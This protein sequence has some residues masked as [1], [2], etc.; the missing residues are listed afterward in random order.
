L[1]GYF[2]RQ[3]TFRLR[4][5]NFFGTD[6]PIIAG[7][8]FGNIGTGTSFIMSCPT[9]AFIISFFGRLGAIL[10]AVGVVCSDGSTLGPFGDN[11]GVPS[12]TATCHDGFSSVEV[13]YDISNYNTIGGIVVDCSGS[14]SR[15]DGYNSGVVNK[16]TCPAGQVLQTVQGTEGQYVY[17]LQFSCTKAA[18]KL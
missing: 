17:S 13:D 8:K 10:D 1:G 11:G 14:L 5:T 6:T 3:V 15:L 2:A 12:S 16:F 7:T 4:L 18:G 9:G